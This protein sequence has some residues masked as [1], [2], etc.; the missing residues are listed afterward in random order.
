M[1]KIEFQFYFWTW[2]IRYIN[3]FSLSVKKT[4]MYFEIVSKMSNTSG[5]SRLNHRCQRGKVSLDSGGNVL[6]KWNTEAT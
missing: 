4:E 3:T 1:M 2:I 6:G 5:S